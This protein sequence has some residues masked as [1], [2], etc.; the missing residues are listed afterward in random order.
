MKSKSLQIVW[1]LDILSNNTKPVALSESFLAALSKKVGTVVKPV[2]VVRLGEQVDPLTHGEGKKVFLENVKAAMKR[3]LIRT[4]IKMEEPAPILQKGI[5]LRSDVDALV[6]HAKKAHADFILV[7]T[8]ARKGLSR[9]WMGSFAETLMHHCSVPVL[10]LN[11]NFKS[12]KQIK[13]IL[14]PTNLS[15]P[16]QKGLM[17]VA[18]FAERI[19]A[20]LILYNNI[21][22]F[23]ATPALSFTETMVFSGN[24]QEDIKERKK[25]L[26]KLASKVKTKHKIKIRTLVDDKDV[27]V[28]DGINR[29]SKKLPNSMIAME[30]QTGPFMSVL[31]GSTTRRVVREASVPVLVLS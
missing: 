27:R 25:N 6:G 9:F 28:S 5:Y 31:V 8:H 14:Y 21:E 10:F 19:Q 13:T 29:L 7:N 30:A 2:Y 4:K 24:V 11:P 23:V 1:A 3:Y 16:A 18:E 15:A 20:E 26:E 22:Y 12:P 17:K